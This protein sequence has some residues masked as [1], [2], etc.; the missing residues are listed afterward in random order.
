MSPPQIERSSSGWRRQRRKLESSG[1]GCAKQWDQESG[2][3]DEMQKQG[4]DKVE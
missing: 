3:G 4:N 2:L 1:L